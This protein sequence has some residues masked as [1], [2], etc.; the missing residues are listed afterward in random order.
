[1]A[2]FIHSETIG[3]LTS[4]LVLFCA[5]FYEPVLVSRTGST[6]G[7]R[8]FNL[9]VVPNI[10]RRL[11]FPR[12]FLRMLLKTILGFVSFFF[13]PLTRRRQALHDI[14]TSSTVRIRDASGFVPEDTTKQEETRPAAP[15]IR[16]ISVIIVYMILAFLL[17]ALALNIFTSPDCLKLRQCTSAERLTNDCAFL[18]WFVVEG[19]IIYFGLRSRLPGARHRALGERSTDKRRGWSGFWS[20]LIW[21]VVWF[22]SLIVAAILGRR[23]L[24][25]VTSAWL[26]VRM[27]EAWAA[28]PFGDGDLAS[29]AY[30]LLETV[31]K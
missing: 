18:G 26:G 19:L 11:S 30:V 8:L 31:T 3:N 14:I 29:M 22:F 7:H 20:G 10:G 9:Q 25:V 21:Y 4:R 16:R 24:L 12:S 28:G 2:R 23:I 6:I 15:L 17:L 27:S 13:V 1:M 5:I